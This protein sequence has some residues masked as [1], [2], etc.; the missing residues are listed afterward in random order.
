[1]CQSRFN[2]AYIDFHIK[3]SRCSWLDCIVTAGAVSNPVTC[4]QCGRQFRM[5]SWLLKHIASKHAGASSWLSPSM[6][7]S[8]NDITCCHSNIGSSGHSRA[9]LGWDRLLAK[10]VF[11]CG[12]WPQPQISTFSIERMKQPPY[13]LENEMASLILLKTLVLWSVVN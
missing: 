12:C 11:C 6:T 4:M 3:V 8:F 10:L 2:A 7:L 1:M 13:Y 5:R 9:S